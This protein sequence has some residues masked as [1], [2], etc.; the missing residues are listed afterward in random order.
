MTT[1]YRLLGIPGS[2][3]QA[4]YCAAVLEAI[5]AEIAPRAE[6]ATAQIGALPLY[7]QD[8]DIEPRPAPVA[9]LR[10]AI[11]AAEGLIVVS[12]E[13][14]HGTPGVLKNAVD[15]ASRP[16]FASPLKDKPVLIV[17]CSMASTGGVRAQYQLREAFASTLSRP[18]ATPEVVI[19]GVHQRMTAGRFTDRAVLDFAAAACTRLFAEIERDRRG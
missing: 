6:T 19:G 2:L 7:N 16:A 11:E 8:L 13:Y 18:V 3:R 5:A 14:N 10:A 12:T 15:W 1:P 9:A 17:T 4:S